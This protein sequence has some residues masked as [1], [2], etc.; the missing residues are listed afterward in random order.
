MTLGKPGPYRAL[1]VKEVPPEVDTAGLLAALLQ[2]PKNIQFTRSCLQPADPQGS[3]EQSAAFRFFPGPRKREIPPAQQ[4][5]P[6]AQ[7]IRPLDR[8]CG[9]RIG[10][11][12]FYRTISGLNI[13]QA[14]QPYRRFSA[15]LV[16]RMPV[17]NSILKLVEPL[18]SR[19][20]SRID[21]ALIFFERKND[22]LE[23]VYTAF[24]AIH[25]FP[26]SRIIQPKAFRCRKAP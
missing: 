12:N 1:I 4:L 10:I 25:I 17:F 18:Q 2:V 9:F 16:L 7:S 6:Q 13:C 14:R 23:L 26:H 8:R 19:Y 11:G 5:M 3:P 20:D 21:S 15:A 22:G 24:I